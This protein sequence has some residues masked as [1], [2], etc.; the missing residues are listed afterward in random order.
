M[1]G[2]HA[3]PIGTSWLSEDSKAEV[4]IAPVWLIN[5]AVIKKLLSIK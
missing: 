2:C 5:E 3:P 1:D 4:F